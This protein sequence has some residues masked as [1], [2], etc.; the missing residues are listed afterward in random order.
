MCHAGFGCLYP[1]WFFYHS[2]LGVTLSI[3]DFSK[4]LFPCLLVSSLR[5]FL[6]ILL[7]RA[8]LWAFFHL[9]I[10]FV[11][12]RERCWDYIGKGR[13]KVQAEKKCNLEC[14]T[15]QGWDLLSWLTW[16]KL[17]IIVKGDFIF[18]ISIPALITTSYPIIIT[19]GQ[20]SYILEKEN[21]WIDGT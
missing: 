17:I 15:M 18:K 14:Y 10:F 4:S 5:C 16:I 2:M 20:I 9:L 7:P 11:W 12:K 3:W 19:W 13:S 8:N 6:Q 21:T 1:P